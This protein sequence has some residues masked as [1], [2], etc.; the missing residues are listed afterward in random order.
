MSTAGDFSEIIAG[1][2]RL[3]QLL[4]QAAARGLAQ[5]AQALEAD[6]LGTNAY[7][8]DTGGTRAG[9]VAYVATADDDGSAA[10]NAAYGAAETENP[11]HGASEEAGEQPDADTMYVVLTVAT[12]Y[13]WVLEQGH[14]GAHAF[15]GRT[16]Q[17]HAAAIQQAAAAAVAEALA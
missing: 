8:D 2:D 16:M 13:A 6:A 14:G 4:A 10:F 7:N 1:L 12:D 5:G 11:G 3:P 15:V 17:E 9:T